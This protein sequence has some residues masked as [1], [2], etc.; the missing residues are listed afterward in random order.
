[1]RQLRRRRDVACFN[2]RFFNKWQ[3]MAWLRKSATCRR[4]LPKSWRYREGMALVDLLRK[5]GELYLKPEQG[6]AGAGIMVARWDADGG[7]RLMRQPSAAGGRGGA[8]RSAVR[9]SHYRT[10]EAWQQAVQRAIGGERYYVQQGVALL[11]HHGRPFDLR[12][13]LQKTRHGRW[14]VTGIGARVAGATSITTH[15]PRGGSIADPAALLRATFGRK[16]TSAL[17]RQ[18][19][20]L[21]PRIARQIERASGDQLGEL[22]L[23]IGIDQQARPWLF[24]ANAKPMSFDEPAIHAR[25]LSTFF[26]YCHYLHKR[27]KT[28]NQKRTSL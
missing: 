4:Y 27:V 9:I 12:L 13:L 15:V 19:H 24:E 7:A 22:S 5:H 1:M 25:A 11:R 2:S 21:A 17:T 16:Q 6:R 3:L 18:L 14:A 23:D 28:A 8:G 26:D 10:P 20:Q